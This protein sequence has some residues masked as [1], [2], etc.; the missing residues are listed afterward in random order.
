MVYSYPKITLRFSSVDIRFV[1]PILLIEISYMFEW[2]WSNQVICLS[3][4]IVE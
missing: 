1:P 3:G 2:M 4:G